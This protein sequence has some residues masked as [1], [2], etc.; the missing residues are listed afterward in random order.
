MASLSSECKNRGLAFCKLIHTF[1]QLS[2]IFYALD[3]LSFSAPSTSTGASAQKTH[4]TRVH[5]L[6]M[7]ADW[8]APPT[9]NKRVTPKFLVN[10]T[11]IEK[12][13]HEV[14]LDPRD[15]PTW[16]SQLEIPDADIHPNDVEALETWAK[17]E[18]D[19]IFDTT[20]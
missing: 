1:L 14:V 5:A 20:D 9:K 16:W 18:T 19:I 4:L 6:E 7:H 8:D 10:P 2:R 17:E 13:L 12:G 11:W 3:E 15:P